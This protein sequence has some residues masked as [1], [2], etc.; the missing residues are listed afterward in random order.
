MQNDS[1]TYIYIYID[2]YTYIYPIFLTQPFETDIPTLRFQCLRSH[3][4][5][6]SLV[7]FTCLLVLENHA[8]W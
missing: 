5:V 8:A 7:L 3:Y 6:N 2:I 1:V 4:P